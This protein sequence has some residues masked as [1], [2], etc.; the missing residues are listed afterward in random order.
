M[1]LN[2]NIVIDQVAGTATGTVIVGGTTIENIV[3][4][5][6]SNTITL[7][8]HVIDA[9]AITD[10]LNLLTFYIVYNS[11]IIQAFFPVSSFTFTP[12]TKVTTNLQD[13]G[14]NTLEFDYTATNRIFQF[15]GTYPNGTVSIAARANIGNLSYAQY[16]DFLYQIANFKLFTLHAYKL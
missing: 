13:D 1:A 10:F 2:T 5:N 12:F 11:A 7:S 6:S 14:I 4:T 9:I 16:L 3:F 15:T 8:P